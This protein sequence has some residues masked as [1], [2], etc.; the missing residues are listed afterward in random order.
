MSEY[1]HWNKKKWL[2]FW[3]SK[4]ESR[5]G[6]F[7]KTKII[8][9]WRKRLIYCW[10]GFEP[11]E[12]HDLTGRHNWLYRSTHCHWLLTNCYNVLQSLLGFSSNWKL[13]I[14]NNWKSYEWGTLIWRLNNSS[15]DIMAPK[16]LIKMR[17]LH[18]M[19]LSFDDKQ[20]RVLWTKWSHTGWQLRPF[21]RLQ[22]NETSKL[23]NKCGMTSSYY[24]YQSVFSASQHTSK[25]PA[26]PLRIVFLVSSCE[27]TALAK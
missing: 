14:G 18:V 17:M 1:N 24:W 27:K 8:Y 22:R 16:R 4:V 9:C 20:R 11:S 23:K 12:V 10:R 3:F 5:N 19:K 2:L 25:Q 7:F 21:S 26:L 6:K 13:F 15:K